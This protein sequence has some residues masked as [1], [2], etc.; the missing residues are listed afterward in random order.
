[1]PLIDVL[2]YR[3]YL[4][5]LV[6]VRHGNIACLS[7][8]RAQLIAVV[9]VLD[10]IRHVFDMRHVSAVGFILGLRQTGGQGNLAK[11]TGSG[12]IVSTG[13][14]GGDLDRDAGTVVWA[15]EMGHGG[16]RAS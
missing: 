7:L 15:G 16:G 5:V 12:C 13:R 10:M 8:Q 3:Y 11:G 1:M 14:V 6:I 4:P 2:I 9:D